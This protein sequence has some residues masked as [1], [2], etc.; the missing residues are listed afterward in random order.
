MPYQIEKS[1]QN[2]V[3][4][5]CDKCRQRK[6]RCDAA[7]PQCKR[8][9]ELGH[10]CVYS[11]SE[12]QLM[13]DSRFSAIHDHLG[14]VD[15]AIKSL[16]SDISA[17]KYNLSELLSRCGTGFKGEESCKA[18]RWLEASAPE[19][20]MDEAPSFNDRLAHLKIHTN[21]D[22]IST[23]V[24]L[25]SVFLSILSPKDISSL[26]RVLEDQSLPQRLETASYN[27]WCKTQAAYGRLMAPSNSNAF[28]PN[29]ALMKAGIGAFRENANEYIRPLLAPEEL[30]VK[31]WTSLPEP[32]SNGLKAALI[33]I[34]SVDMRMRSRF[35]ELSKTL[36]D[37][38]ERAA[39]F[40]A[41]RTLN[42][43]RFSRPSFLSVRLAILL[44][45]LLVVFSNL[46]GLFNLLDPI[47]EMCRAIKLD[48]PSS[49]GAYPSKLA[50]WRARVWFLGSNL[51]YCYYVTLSLKPFTP[52]FSFQ[53]LSQTRFRWPELTDSERILKCTIKIH[54]IYDLAFEKL[55]SVMG[56]KCSPNELLHDVRN[57]G[58]EL[59]EWEKEFSWDSRDIPELKSFGDFISMFALGN[60]NYKFLHTIITVYSIPAFHPAC[61][62]EP[63][64]GSLKKVSNAARE[65]FKIALISE[66]IKNE[67]TSVNSIAVTTA[68]CSLLYKQLCYPKEET[69]LND[70]KMLRDNIHR[71][72]QVRW[73]SIDNQSPQVEIWQVLLDI[74]DRHYKIHN[75]PREHN[76][77]VN[78]EQ[79]D[80][81][82]DLLTQEYIEDTDQC[83]VT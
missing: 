63:V 5:A 43:M 47:L 48:S 73:P 9:R 23:T 36:I 8:C 20:T 35:E 60:I 68:V 75:I 1:K 79:L 16:S 12:R 26:A 29:E 65:L 6:I 24:Y 2:R 70:L 34:G 77:K 46:P 19:K 52:K 74:M 13:S 59:D 25:S 71:L 51:M 4:V 72:D 76:A 22:Q 7:K 80:L 27:V 55:F 21:G 18:G 49:Q 42:L 61:L 50:D 54:E 41:V 58:K 83:I 44:S 11:P 56:R 28:Q 30:D 57:L 81:W 40:Q 15:E 82:N 32:L 53:N 31:K 3:A 78:M 45:L 39:Y 66:D 14:D 10:M 62:P 69:N 17:I 37:S 64:P 33:I 38:Q 67:C